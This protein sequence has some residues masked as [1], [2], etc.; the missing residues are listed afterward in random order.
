MGL[1]VLQIRQQ[2][3]K[4]LFLLRREGQRLR[5]K[6]DIR[7]KIQ[8]FILFGGSNYALF[9]KGIQRSLGD[10][11]LVQLASRLRAGA[12]GFHRGQLPRAGF[13]L[14]GQ[15]P[16]QRIKPLGR[17]G[18]AALHHRAALFLGGTILRTV[19]DDRFD[20]LKPGTERAFF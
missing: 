6:R 4:S 1:V 20:C 17:A 9:A 5:V 13:W 3:R 19:R 2:R 18:Q 16:C 11:R 7:K 14:F 10:A 15:F 8:R 12:E